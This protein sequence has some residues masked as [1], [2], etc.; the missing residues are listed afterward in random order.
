MAWPY[1][2]VIEADNLSPAPLAFKQ[3]AEIL[4]TSRQ[5][6]LVSLEKYIVDTEHYIIQLSVLKGPI[7]IPGE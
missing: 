1:Q 7:G 2:W 5:D 3:S 4:A 6:A